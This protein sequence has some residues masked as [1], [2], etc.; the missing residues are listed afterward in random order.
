MA[1]SAFNEKFSFGGG[2]LTAGER[3]T[4]VLRD[5]IL[6]EGVVAYNP[7]LTG[8]GLLGKEVETL[9]DDQKQL[10]E[11]T[12]PLTW[13]D[14]TERPKTEDVIVLVF[15][16]PESGIKTGN[17]DITFRVSGAKPERRFREFLERVTGKTVGDEPFTIG[18]YL[19]PGM[20]FTAVA[21]TKGNFS[22]FDRDSIEP[23]VS[24]GDG[25]VPK[26][27]RAAISARILKVFKANA[28]A[29]NGKPASILFGKLREFND[30]GEFSDIDWIE[31]VGA[32]QEV[33]PKVVSGDVVAIP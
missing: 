12:S 28:E 32:Y 13:D 3:Y 15:E 8:T 22:S 33:K 1:K 6:R 7:A 19:Q 27:D 9:D 24:G 11:D 18:D 25:S 5:V 30:Q 29:L 10:L 17:F 26:V 2:V 14:G 31:L 16:E 21:T 4:I 23:A 20:E